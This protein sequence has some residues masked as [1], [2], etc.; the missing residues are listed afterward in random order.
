[1]RSLAKLRFPYVRVAA[2]ALAIAAA[3]VAQ[4][5]DS[6]RYQQR[7]LV[8]DGFIS[9][10]HVDPNLVN[11]WGVAFNP[12]GFVWVADADGMV[13]TLYDG[14]G[15]ANPLVV[16]IPTPLAGTG[17]NPTG[18]V[19]NGSNGFV[20]TNGTTSGAARFLF[21]TEQ[22]VIA[23]WAPTVDGTHALRAVDRSG[24]GAIYKG[25]ALSAGGNGQLLYA[26]DFFNARVDVFN[27]SFQPVAFGTGAF[28]DPKLPA[29]YAPF[30]IQALGGDIYVT[31]AKQN[32]DRDEE[33]AGQGLGF[34]D[35]YDP[36]G[37]LLRRVASHG[38]LNAPWGLALAPAGFGGFGGALLVGNFGDGH[39]NGYDP[40]FGE[41]LGSLRGADGKPVAIDGLWGI[42]FG[43]GLQH[44]P[45]DTL[46]FASGPDDEA[47]G[48]YGRLDPIAGSGGGGHDDEGDDND[49]GEDDDDQGNNNQGNNNEGKDKQNSGND[50]G[51]AKNPGKFRRGGGADD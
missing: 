47:H 26:T 40:M 45:V 13:S 24:M 35:V 9:A 16:Q 44:Q 7:N 19:F 36:N 48:L 41:L 4:A 37:M 10:D 8:S 34:V 2:L 42:A 21:A 31:Y 38:Q 51:V 46:F 22:G 33:V 17:G 27:S 39:I 1:M 28:T 3:G 49:Q 23:G 15:N 14:D 6:G 20:V 25:L 32:A 29:G 12:F 30:G 5:A 18:I 50:Q 11:A 43:N